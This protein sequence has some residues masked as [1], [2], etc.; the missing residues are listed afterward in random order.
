MGAAVGADPVHLPRCAF[1]CVCVGV[2]C[3]W[4]VIVTVCV[5]GVC[6]RGVGVAAGGLGTEG[7]DVECV[8]PARE[9]SREGRLGLGA[10]WVGGWV[11]G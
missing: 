4:G 6:A 1:L 9:G 7:G 11:V 3:A 2:V 10:G 8:R 5:C